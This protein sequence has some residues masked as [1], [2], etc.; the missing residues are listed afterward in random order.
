[1]YFSTSDMQWFPDEKEWGEEPK[2]IAE[3]SAENCDTFL[4]EGDDY[5]IVE[6]NQMNQGSGVFCS[7]QEAEAFCDKWNLGYDFI[8]KDTISEL[9]QW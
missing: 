5:Y 7:L 1:M 2:L 3:C 6:A 9:D 8:S 4:Y